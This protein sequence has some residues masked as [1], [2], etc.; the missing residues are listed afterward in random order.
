MQHLSVLF[1]ISMLFIAPTIHAADEDFS[2]NLASF[3]CVIGGVSQD[4]LVLVRAS[5]EDG[6]P[7]KLLLSRQLNGREIQRYSVQNITRSRTQN[8]MQIVVRGVGRQSEQITLLLGVGGKLDHQAVNAAVVSVTDHVV[9][10]AA[11]CQFTLSE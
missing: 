1:I 4:R 2:Q 11:S 5:D 6:L 7:N 3:E 10:E 8:P 9:S